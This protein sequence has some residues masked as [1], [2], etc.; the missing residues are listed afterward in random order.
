MLLPKMVL[1]PLLQPILAAGVR[2]HVR[3]LP[4]EVEGDQLH[5]ILALGAARG[6][7]PAH[8]HAVGEF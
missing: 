6:L 1:S 7:Y 2:R 5:R 8:G 4:A 3:A